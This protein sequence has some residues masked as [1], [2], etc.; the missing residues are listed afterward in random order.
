[1]E[2]YEYVIWIWTFYAMSLPL[3]AG[4]LWRPFTRIG[5]AKRVGR[6]GLPVPER[7][8]LK[9]TAYMPLKS[10]GDIPTSFLK[11]REK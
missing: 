2:T 8:S 10:V 4:R 7:P 6:H 1:M 9:K 11:K 3:G 5:H